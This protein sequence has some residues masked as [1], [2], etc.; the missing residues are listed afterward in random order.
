MG[1]ADGLDERV[2][3]GVSVAPPGPGRERSQEGRLIVA[4][5]PRDEPVS[6]VCVN[7]NTYN[8]EGLFGLRV[9]SLGRAGCGAAQEPE[10]R[11]AVLPVP[12]RLRV[13]KGE[14][15]APE[16]AS[17]VSQHAVCMVRVIPRAVVLD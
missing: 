17:R 10:P 4:G 14:R 9:W 16:I 12:V 3:L 15:I 5:A 1:A 2:V 7:I 8:C 13:V 11:S 6:K